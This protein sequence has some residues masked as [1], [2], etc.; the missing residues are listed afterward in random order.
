MQKE[1][2]LATD[3]SDMWRRIASGPTSHP[4]IP[5]LEMSK[6]SKRSEYQANVTFELTYGLP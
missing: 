5:F 2:R 4:D 6:N 1:R 3:L